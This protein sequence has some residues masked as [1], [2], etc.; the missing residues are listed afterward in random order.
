M[1]RA[2]YAH[3]RE[4]HRNQSLRVGEGGEIGIDFR[5]R[6]HAGFAGPPKETG[7]GTNLNL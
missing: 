5:P 1:D 6:D 2:S 7:F 3:K 4:A